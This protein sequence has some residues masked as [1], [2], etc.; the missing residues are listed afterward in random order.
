MSA[1]SR[2]QFRSVSR[3]SRQTRSAA[4]SPVLDAASD[5]IGYYG[6]PVLKRPVWTWEVPAYFFTGGTAGAAALLAA[7]AELRG[8][9]ELARTARRVAAGG[10]LAS[11]PLLVSDL[12]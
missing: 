7:G 3:R 9:T 11:G 12:G 4:D 1:I 6:R 8:R 10:A 2:F 5:T